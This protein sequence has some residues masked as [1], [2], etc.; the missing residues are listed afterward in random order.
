M[1]LLPPSL[2]QDDGFIL[3]TERKLALDAARLIYDYAY[4]VDNLLMPMAKAAGPLSEIPGQL[5]WVELQVENNAKIGRDIKAWEDHTKKQ[6]P[7]I[8][9]LADYARIFQEFPVPAVTGRWQDDGV[10]ANQRLAGL[11][12]MAIKRVTADG[13]VGLGWGNLHK[14]LS[15]HITDATLSA[16]M[17]EPTTFD[18]AI[19]AGLLYVAD[20][21]FLSKVVADANAVGDEK[22]KRLLAPIGLFV[23]RPHEQGLRPVAV[24]LGQLP[25]DPVHTPEPSP[26][27]LMAKT[28]LQTA[29]INLNQLVNHLGL[30]HLIQDAFAI[31]MHRQMDDRHPIRRLLYWH[32]RAMLIINFAGEKVLVGSKGIVAQILESGAVGST[33]VINDAYQTWSFD[34]LDPRANIASR[35]LDDPKLLPYFPYRDD[36]LLIF[37]LLGKYI[38]EY[39]ALYYGQPDDP[40]TQTRITEDWELQGWA[41]ELAPTGPGKVQGFP[42]KIDSFDT[43]V[44]VLHLMIWTAGPQHAAVNF[45]QIEFAGFVPNLPGANYAAPVEGTVTLANIMEMMPPAEQTSEQFRTTWQLAGV[46]LDSL[47]DYASHFDGAAQELISRYFSQLS[48]EVTTTINAA[49]AQRQQLGLLEYPWLL[50]ANIPNSTSV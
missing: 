27:W 10:F 34:K 21:Q 31:A 46:H 28:Y 15:Q 24:Q 41:A 37:D 40:A 5:R 18:A 6:Q 4:G 16:A 13:V 42:S 2:P 8:A 50:P 14:K 29:D 43:L 12:P 47:L 35:G 11:N 3:R 44:R 48:G 23:R 45:P 38:R 19:A 49:N 20:Y 36:G 9:N 26:A 1:S 25:T 32:F 7:P 17:G 39:V 30:V 22:G 33:D